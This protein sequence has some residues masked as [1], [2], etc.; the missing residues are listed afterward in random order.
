M[1]DR[2]GQT[3]LESHA[4]L[5][6]WTVL[7]SVLALVLL[8]ADPGRRHRLLETFRPSAPAWAY[9]VAVALAYPLHIY[10]VWFFP[11]Y[12]Y[13]L[14]VPLL[15][16]LGLLGDFLLD[17][18]PGTRMRALA[19]GGL[20]V[21]LLATWGARRD[22]RE[23]FSSQDTASRGYMNLGLWAS[24]TL[25][26]GTAIGSSQ[27]G[28][29]SYFAPTLRV[30]N[31]DGVVNRACLDSLLRRRN[32]DY[33]LDSGVEYVVGWT[34]NIRF[35][36]V[37]SD[38]PIEPHLESLGVIPGFRSW[39]S[40]WHLY[41]VRRSAAPRGVPSAPVPPHEKRPGVSAGPE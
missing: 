8:A 32:I 29:L 16:T 11:R 37:L 4:S 26:P 30:V 31:L 19:T 15:L 9:G 14:T 33:I 10:A 27:S 35:I 34:V 25:P 20:V 41:R 6:G 38:R 5:L 13:P 23:L 28:A 3:V 12:L 7:L 18:L 2:A 17:A 24:R 39:G 21:A 22:L 40:E 1:L 36:K